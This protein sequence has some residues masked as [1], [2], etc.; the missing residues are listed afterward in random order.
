MQMPS[1]Q[2]VTAHGGS[3]RQGATAQQ[4]TGTRLWMTHQ[5]A[6]SAERRETQTVKHLK[7]HLHS[8]LGQAQVHRAVSQGPGRVAGEEWAAKWAAVSRKC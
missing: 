1:T 6:V 4:A 8:M 5:G 3:P 7:I 2:S